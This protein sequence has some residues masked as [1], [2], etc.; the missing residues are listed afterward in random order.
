MKYVFLLW[1]LLGIYS[2]SFSQTIII[3][4]QQSKQPVD[5][6]TL[7]SN[8][9]KVFTITNVHGKA[10]ISKFK[11]SNKI[12]IRKLG[13]ETITKS[14]AELKQMSWQLYMNKSNLNLEEVVVAA[15]RWRQR[16]E[17]IPSKITSI[18]NEQVAIQNPQTAAD[19]LGISGE[20]YIQKSQQGGGSPM[21]RGFA[22]NRLLY[23][24]DGI[25]MNT[26][27]FRSGNIQNVISLDPF[28]IESTEVLYG[29]GSVIY[30][31]D[32]I[33]GVMSFR[34]L[35]PALSL[36][37]ETEI[38]GK[39]ISRYSTAN[40]EKTAHFD[41]NVGWKKWA[42]LTSISSFDYGAL[43]QGSN[44]PDDYLKSHY[45]KRFDSAD[46]IVRQDNPL[47]Q[48]P[49]GYSQMNI[50]Q[51]VRFRPN[52][53]WEFNYG[54]H[55]SET[56]SYGR[57]DRHNRMDNNLPKYGQWD[58]GP[59][60][61]MMNNLNITQNTSNKLYDKM[62]IRLALQYFEES[63][64]DRDLNSDE[65]RNRIE[66]IDAYSL[67]VDFNKTVT[68]KNELFYGVEYVRND[69]HSEAFMKNIETGARYDILTRY[70]QSDWSSYGI[71][72]KDQYT[73]S[74]KFTMEGGLRYNQFVINTSFD[75]AFINVPF[76]KARL[77]NG[78]LT[79]NLGL[80]YH[81]SPDFIFK[82][83]AS[84]GFRSPNVDDIGKVFD[85]EPGS[86]V[87]PNPDLKAEYA[88]NADL[89]VAKVFDKMVKLDLTVY[90]TILQNALVRRDYSL[91]GQDSIL[92]DGTLSQVQ[93]IQNAAV[94]SRY[95]IQAMLEVKLPRNFT[96]STRI[97]YQ[98]G[99][100]EMDDGSISPPR[101]AAPFFGI[102]RLSYDAQK[103]SLQ[104]YTRFQGERKH[105]DIAISERDKVEIYALD[106]NGN[107][108]APSWYTLNLKALYNIN[109]NFSLSSGIENLTDQRYRSYSSGISAPGRNFFISVRAKF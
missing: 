25:R 11:G 75:T 102:S 51:K 67:N 45:V 62:I 10:D 30:G 104:F 78:A 48:R 66:K 101:H 82:A 88:Y 16:S 55:Y 59:Q 87:V 38:S 71:Y 22:T 76:T 72:I 42:L 99:K 34:T 73:I 77:N 83:N 1:L 97:N 33:G 108:Y 86:V 52:N 4:D 98:D 89:G 8:T 32:A 29:P 50:M 3:K 13:Y 39:A 92:Y 81:P 85:S 27:I 43:R 28:S 90:Y 20:V 18:S 17:N 5:L 80:S 56:S 19:L 105:E 26:A 106:E 74:D 2:I 35:K 65:Q 91:N 15:T 23:T 58:Y 37:K 70:P 68:N 49:S 95:G 46:H 109:E 107:T 57:Y 6:A 79:G 63:R 9:P 61:W 44:G 21:I 31:S 60:K 103:L 14:Y 54:F 40:H 69:V 93:A 84:T 36:N 100:D 41:V 64:I 94:A 53:Q 24:I 12:E 47:I 7:A 96:F